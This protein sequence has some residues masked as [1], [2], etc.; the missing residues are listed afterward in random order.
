MER[1]IDNEQ[2]QQA[3][4]PEMLEQAKLV[5]GNGIT[6][7]YS[8]KFREKA[9]QMIQKSPTPAAG[10]ARVAA[11]IGGRIF[12]AAKEKGDAISP[13]VLA[14][15]GLD[16]VQ[17]VAEFAEKFADVE[18]SEEVIEDAFYVASDN[19]REMLGDD[20]PDF[21]MDDPGPE[22]GDRAKQRAMQAM[23]GGMAQQ[24]APAPSGGLGRAPQ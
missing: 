20:A 22:A 10:I 9:M 3:L 14:V 1:V 16:L 18:V 12:H 17:E 7:L 2:V 15:A 5:L 21:E 8:A 23:T 19:L 11:T 13:E 6:A 4:P 24:Q